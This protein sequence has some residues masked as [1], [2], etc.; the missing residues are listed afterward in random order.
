M[1]GI[2]YGV[3]CEYGAVYIVKT[4]R[5]LKTILSE[6]K[7]AVQHDDIRNGLTVYVLNIDHCIN[8]EEA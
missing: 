4:G 1:K 6:H 5:S 7:R 8:W 2:I 3:P